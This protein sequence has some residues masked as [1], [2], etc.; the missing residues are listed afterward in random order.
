MQ[1]TRTA[2]VATSAWLVTASAMAQ[3][4][5]GAR[6]RAGIYQDDDY[7][8]VVTAAAEA[9]VEIEET[10]ALR[11]GYLVDVTSSASVDVV[12]AAT[13]RWVERRDEFRGGTDLY[14]DR[15]IISADYVRSV[16][17]DW[18]SHRITGGASTEINNR[19]TT[20]S[21]GLGLILNNVGRAE[22]DGSQGAFE[23]SQET[24]ALNLG[25]VQILNRESLL[26]LRYA[27]QLVTGFQASPYR[28]ARVAG[29]QVYPETHPDV[30]HRHA[31]VIQYRHALSSG[32]AFG[33]DERLYI[34]S[35]SVFGTTTVL[36]LGFELTEI[37]DLELRNRFHF[38][39]AASFYEDEYATRQQYMTHD[40]E[41]STFLDNYF[42]PS[43]VLQ[44]GPT[45]PFENLTFDIS[46]Q[47]FVYHFFNFSELPNRYGFVANIGIGGEL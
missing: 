9:H 21:F 36:T 46:A 4:T 5:N 18:N 7:T 3:P 17:P 37:F 45:G 13:G 38:Q 30:R 16:E 25:L 20:L 31:A 6:I 22:E 43:L 44:T 28:F 24:Y 15:T 29:G 32:V 27:G 12:S 2:L 8:T 35:W 10:V 14:I 40:R 23:Q 11:G 26:S 39:S 42:G 34:D 33:I 41:L 47:G 19:A 1:L